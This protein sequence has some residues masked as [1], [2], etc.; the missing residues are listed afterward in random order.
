[1]D[2]HKGRQIEYCFV[3]F[4]KLELTFLTRKIK[5]GHLVSDHPGNDNFGTHKPS[6]CFNVNSPLKIKKWNIII[7]IPQ[8]L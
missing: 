7:G 4:L 3:S 8:D 6:E 5:V 1:M 2:F